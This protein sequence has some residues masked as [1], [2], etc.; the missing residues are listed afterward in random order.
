MKLAI[1]GTGRIV[2][3]AL[4]AM[5]PLYQAGPITLSAIFAHPHGRIEGDRKAAEGT[6]EETAGV[7]DGK[8]TGV[9]A[10]EAARKAEP[11]MK[12]YRIP[13]VYTD[14]EKLL[15]E[16]DADTVYIALAN[17]VHYEYAKTALIA[18]KNVI[19][20]KPFTGR[21]AEAEELFSMAEEKGLF[22][23]EAATVLHSDVLQK[24]QEI[25]PSLGKVQS[26]SAN[27]E[28]YSSAY[29]AYLSGEVKPVFDPDNFG[30]ALYDIG[31]Y[32]LYYILALFGAPKKA[33]YS[34]NRGWNGI[35]TS[36]TLTLEYSGFSAFSKAAKDSDG[37]SF[38]SIDC[39]KGRL[40]LK[41]KPNIALELLITRKTEISSG[42][43]EETE[44]FY[45]PEPFHR[46]TPE[47]ADFA[48]IIDTG[49]AEAYR[50]FKAL[51][52]KVMAV[53]EAAKH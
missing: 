19:L 22:I 29:P 15:S 12:A 35:D 53:L 20:E 52:L 26:V 14:Y 16:T 40:Y 8:A 6:P 24:M 2:K 32:N 27:Y 45:A 44:V 37:E 11:F 10:E 23:L 36:G 49:D 41:G 5:T 1:I 9:A 38:I 31:V 18:G 50:R 46:L 39:E 43:G 21:M 34:P 13:K 51:T 33:V 42:V 28:Q 4:Y 17:G 25:L 48:K 30:G 47:F 7:A 3:E